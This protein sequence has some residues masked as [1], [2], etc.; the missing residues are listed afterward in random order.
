MHDLRCLSLLLQ[1]RVQYLVIT[2]LCLSPP[3]L[4]YLQ[5]KMLLLDAFLKG[6]EIQFMLPRPLCHAHFVTPRSFYSPADQVK[7]FKDGTEIAANEQISFLQ[8][9]RILFISSVQS[10]N[11]G[12]YYC[13]I[14]QVGFDNAL[15]STSAYLEMLSE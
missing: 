12:R 2:H 6:G 1:I 11:E 5:E 9:K 14:E 4:L 13:Q 3:M 10:S 7:W 8:N 15:S